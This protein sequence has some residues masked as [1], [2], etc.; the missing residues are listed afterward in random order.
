[1]QT[2]DDLRAG[3]KTYIDQHGL[4][5]AGLATLAGINRGDVHHWMTGRRFLRSDKLVAVLGVIGGS[6][7]LDARRKPTK[8]V[9]Q[10][11]H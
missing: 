11:N 2:H 9:S 3:V 1:M 8:V 5:V 10:G 4:S 6:V 7:K